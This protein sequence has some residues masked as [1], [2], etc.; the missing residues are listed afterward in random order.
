MGII[1]KCLTIWYLQPLL[2]FTLRMLTVE[3]LHGHD[4]RQEDIRTKQYKRLCGVSSGV[5]VDYD[6]M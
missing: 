4:H 6:R 5:H 3:I 2:I 1:L